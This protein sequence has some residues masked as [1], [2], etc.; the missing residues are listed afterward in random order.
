[1]AAFPES[2]SRMV[3]QDRS[4]TA[5]AT[6]LVEAPNLERAALVLLGDEPSH[7]AD[8]EQIPKLRAEFAVQVAQ[9]ASF[10]WPTEFRR[11]LLSVAQEDAERHHWTELQAHALK[12]LGDLDLREARLEQARENYL[13][14]LPI[15]T[16]IQENIGLANT[17]KALGNL[18]SIQG[19]TGRAVDMLQRSLDIDTEIQNM[20][21]VRA[22]HGY[23]GQHFMRND[24]PREAALAF[25]A[26][27]QA[28]SKQADP[29]GYKIA[30][31]GQL[32]AFAKLND[33]IGILA[34]LKVLADMDEGLEERYTGLLNSIKEQ[35]PDLSEL[36]AALNEDAD[37]VRRQ[38]VA[39]LADDSEES[40]SSERPHPE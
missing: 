24:Q 6:F 38:A 29:I 39:R 21:G 9:F 26:S 23:L 27:L 14:V 19:E 8:S 33:I 40:S 12:A 7:L 30:F 37:E 17:L 13:K 35:N 36:E 31:Q 4:N 3:S 1:M 15:F 5:I 25:E 2:L 11:R 18:A 32:D 20:L 22:D 28:L 10:L 16:D 34:C